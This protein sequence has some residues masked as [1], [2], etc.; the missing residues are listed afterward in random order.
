MHNDHARGLIELLKDRTLNIMTAWMHDM[1]NHASADTLRRA[2]SGNSSQAD[3]VKEAL[4]RTEELARAFASRYITPQEP[5]AG[6]RIAFLPGL[7]VLGP[8][9]QFYKKAL[10]ESIGEPVPAFGSLLSALAGMPP[11]MYAPAPPPRLSLIS[12]ILAQPP[13]PAV[14]LQFLGGPLSPPPRMPSTLDLSASLFGVLSNSSVE[15]KPKTQPFNNTSVI[16]GMLYGDKK[17]LFTGDAGADALDAVSA[18]WNDLH[19]MQVPHHGSD[20]NL[21][22]KNIERFCPRNAYI[23]AVGDLCHPDRAI[24]NG[25]IK[26]RSQVFSTHT[27][28]HLWH[29][30]GTV[31]YR[32]GYGE[33]IPLKGNSPA[34]PLT[35]SYPPLPMRFTSR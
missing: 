28:G 18:S 16:L 14:P 34:T 3:D 2:K 33:A 27:G 19:W 4:E 21:S 22:Q 5:F 12:S 30:T 25:L 32:S 17:F 11:S 1:R 9:P 29:H 8:T 7:T 6:N 15:E 13:S 24:V 23:S 31:P 10:E 26:V 35:A 20:G